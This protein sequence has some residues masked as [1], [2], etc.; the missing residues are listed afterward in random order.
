MYFSTRVSTP[1]VEGGG[2]EQPLTTLGD[3]VEDARHLEEAHV[4]HVVGLVEDGDLDLVEV[5]GTA[6]HEVDESARGGDEQVDALGQRIDLLVV[7]QTA[8]DQLVPQAADVD[9]RLEGVADLHG[10]LTGRDEHE[11]AGPRDSRRCRRPAG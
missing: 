6:I 3:G 11:G 5:D 9:E 4:G 7:G 8:G 10:E 1:V 2:E